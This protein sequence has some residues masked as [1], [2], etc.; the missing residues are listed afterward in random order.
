MKESVADVVDLYHSYDGFLRIIR[1]ILSISRQWQ[2]WLLLSSG[3]YWIFIRIHV[4]DTCPRIC[5]VEIFNECFHPSSQ[6]VYI[7]REYEH[8]SC[9]SK[10]RWKS[11]VSLLFPPAFDC[12]SP[13]SLSKT[14][15][16]DRHKSD[17]E[18]IGE[19]LS[20]S[21]AILS[22]PIPFLLHSR[23]NNSHLL[24]PIS[25]S[26]GGQKF[27]NDPFLESNGM[28]SKRTIRFTYRLIDRSLPR[29]DVEYS[30]AGIFPNK[31]RRI[32]V[33]VFHNG[34]KKRMTKARPAILHSMLT[35]HDDTPSA[36]PK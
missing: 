28:K 13:V 36:R 19:R 24:N 6:H 22:L 3:G 30:V 15:S 25:F 12:V 18:R 16:H 9:K 32:N 35:S 29:V 27:Q 14:I 31:Y 2:W 23:V 7:W 11:R 20:G 8:A 17:N 1:S 5:Q 33:G 4:A 34:K 21:R 26:A 10:R